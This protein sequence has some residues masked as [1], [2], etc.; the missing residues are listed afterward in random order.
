MK[1]DG[2]YYEQFIDVPYTGEVTR[3]QQGLFKND[4]AE[5]A[6]FFYWVNG[7]LNLQE[8]QEEWCSGHLPV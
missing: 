8:R 2:L 7:Q 4:K 3:D 6:W 1:R 5:G